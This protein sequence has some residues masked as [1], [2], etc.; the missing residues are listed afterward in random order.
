MNPEL[1]E[2][3][4]IRKTSYDPLAKILRK[5]V[6][7]EKIKAKVPV[8]SSS[9]VPIKTNTQEIGTNSYV[10]PIAGLLLVSYV[11]NNIIGEK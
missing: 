5:M 2:I 3:T 11:I 6:K 9:E 7:E 1:L 4:D 8:V 10:P